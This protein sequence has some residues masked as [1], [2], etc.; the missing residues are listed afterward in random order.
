MSA[1]RAREFYERLAKERQKD[2][3]KTAPGKAKTLKANLP[4]VSPG[5][6]RDQA[7]KVFGVSGK[8]VDHATREA[9]PVSDLSTGPKTR[10]ARNG[11]FKGLAVLRM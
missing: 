5:Q 10:A 4:E 2:H 8:S 9:H 7:G 6:A 11:A 3:G 1:A